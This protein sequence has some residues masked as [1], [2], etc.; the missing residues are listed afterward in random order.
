[1]RE[2]FLTDLLIEEIE[3]SI[4]KIYRFA[5]S[6]SSETPFEATLHFNIKTNGSLAIMCGDCGDSTILFIHE[7]IQ[8]LKGSII[9]NIENH[10]NNCVYKFR[11]RTLKCQKLTRTSIKISF[12]LD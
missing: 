5:S 8:T 3:D 2:K 1:M 4:S 12:V 6:P 7:G 11:N 10:F 9:T